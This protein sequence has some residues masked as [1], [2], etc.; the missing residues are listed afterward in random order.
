MH[1][2]PSHAPSRKVHDVDRD[3]AKLTC[4]IAR[5]EAR[6]STPRYIPEYVLMYHPRQQYVKH[7]FST[8]KFECSPTP[9]HTVLISEVHVKYSRLLCN[10]MPIA[11]R[12]LMIPFSRWFRPEHGCGSLS[13][14]HDTGLYEDQHP[15][16]FAAWLFTH[17]SSYYP[18]TASAL[19]S[20]PHAHVSSIFT[21]ACA[22]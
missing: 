10:E 8:G 17:Q 4:A 16:Q 1:V 15:R 19:C 14:R 11:S 20:L 2:T 13:Q 5:D 6:V 21:V 3:H 7:D 12:L 18:E 9:N 22:R